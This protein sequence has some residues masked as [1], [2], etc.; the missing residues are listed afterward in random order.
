M[1]S[2]V[3]CNILFCLLPLNA[4][5]YVDYHH[6]LLDYVHNLVL[7]STNFIIIGDFSFPD[8]LWVQLSAPS[9]ISSKFGEILF[10]HTVHQLITDT[11]HIKENIVDH[12]GVVNATF[13]WG[14]EKAVNN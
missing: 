8:V 5:V 6:H 2:E 10:D 14:D 1:P 13:S 11:T 4:S 3:L 12:A 7:S 9:H